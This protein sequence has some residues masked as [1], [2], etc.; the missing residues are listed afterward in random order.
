VARHRSSAL[1]VAAVVLGSGDDADDV[2]QAASER[3]WR[4][5][6]A[7]DAGRGFRAWFLHGVAN[8]A[9]NHRRSRWRRR[10]AELRLAVRRDGGLSGVA[11]PLDAAVFADQRAAVLRALNG[12]DRENRLVIALRHFEQLSEREMA[13]VLGC[14]PGTVKSRLSRA[15]AALR[16]RLGE[17]EQ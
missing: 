5:I 3:M 15:M 14:P 13:D 11:D 8:T 17:V 7:V 6:G 1:R 4:S 12:L 9:R 2:V 16:E 10:A